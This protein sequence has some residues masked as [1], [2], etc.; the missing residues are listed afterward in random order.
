MVPLRL[1][2][3]ENTVR[4]YPPVRNCKG[5]I[6]NMANTSLSWM[7]EIVRFLTVPTAELDVEDIAI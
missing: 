7:L 4:I 1:R 2:L 3:L 6:S 5:Y